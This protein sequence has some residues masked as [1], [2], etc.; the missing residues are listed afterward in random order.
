MHFSR[1]AINVI[2]TVA[3]CSVKVN[4]ECNKINNK[5]FVHGECSLK[6]YKVQKHFMLKCIM[7]YMYF[8]YTCS[9]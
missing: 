1:N 2:I 4:Q 5:V 8:I 9:T 3:R 6:M 7:F